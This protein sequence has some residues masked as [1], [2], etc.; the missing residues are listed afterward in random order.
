MATKVATK[1]KLE[2]VKNSSNIAAAGFDKKSKR[3]LVKFSSGTVYEYAGVTLA[4]WNA[5]K[6][7]FK[8]KAS[9]GEFFAAKVKKFPARRVEADEVEALTAA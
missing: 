1:I 6:K 2:E 7:T 9:A 5:F 8:G 4:V 3:L